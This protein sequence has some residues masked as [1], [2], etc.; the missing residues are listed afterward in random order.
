MRVAV[1][2]VSEG[3]EVED[4][5]DLGL[6]EGALDGAAADDGGEVEGCAGDRGDGN[7]LDD[8]D[9]GRGEGCRTVQV[10]AVMAARRPAGHDHVDGRAVGL[11]KT[12]EVGS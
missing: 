6:V 3:V 2:L 7:R 1:Q 8:G 9:V 12:V 10:D 11:A 5:E 4:L